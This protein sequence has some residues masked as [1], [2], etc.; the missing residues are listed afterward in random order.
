MSLFASP[1]S[2]FQSLTNF[3]RL[4]LFSLIPLALSLLTARRLLNLPRHIHKTSSTLTLT[5]ELLIANPFLLALSPA[6]LLTTLLL[7]IPFLTLIFRLLLKG[8]P[9]KESSAWEWHVYSWANWAIIGAIA[10]WLWS[11]GVARGI[12]RMT[13]ASVIGAWYFAEYV[14]FPP[15]F[16][17]QYSPL[18]FS[19]DAL[20]PSPT[21]THIIHSAVMRSTGTSLGT[22]ALSA[23]ILTI[24]RLLTLL[25]LLL[26]RLPVYIP[27][28]A[29][30]LVT[31]VRMV[32]GYLETITTAL[33][34]YA[35]VYS[36]LTGDPFMNSARR[37]QALT[38][39]VEAKA[40]RTRRLGLSAER[41]CFSSM[42]SELSLFF[43]FRDSTIDPPD[44]G[45]TYLDIPIRPHHLPF[46]GTYFGCT[47]TG[48]G[49][50]D[51]CSRCDRA[52]WTVLRGPGRGRVSLVV[53]C[54]FV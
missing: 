19:P 38:R 50:C 4:R 41:R 16:T 17:S 10:I 33:S 49:C 6:I 45:A 7:S 27:A 43:I 22:I 34:K 29:F 48:F 28:R 3:S 13:C 30:F 9:V 53:L 35:L 8:H 40:A 5:T 32:V 25:T 44:S 15:A 24:I 14:H 36:G 2:L 31:G 42:S 21:S 23:L 54:Y 52:C 51:T 37:A 26:H 1:P 12:L 20:L 39:A 47:P 46:R 11:W 18:A